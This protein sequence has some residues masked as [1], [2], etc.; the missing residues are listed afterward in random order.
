M[1]DEKGLLRTCDRCG[2]VVFLKYQRT[3]TLDGG[4]TK[5]DVFEASPPGWDTC[6]V[7]KEYATLCPACAERWQ[8]LSTAFI[9]GRA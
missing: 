8:E 3:D 6:K 4:Y 1:A 9:E 7:G 2:A 5:M